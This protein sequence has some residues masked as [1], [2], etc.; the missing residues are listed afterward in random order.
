MGSLSTPGRTGWCDDPEEIEI[1]R[2]QD[3]RRYANDLLLVE[4][5]KEWLLEDSN[6]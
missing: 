3:L 5:E 1:E 2:Q 6:D 4:R